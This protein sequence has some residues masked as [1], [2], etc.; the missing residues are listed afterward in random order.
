[1][2]D[3]D[4]A[5]FVVLQREGQCLAHFEVEVVGRLVEQQQ[6]GFGADQQG[7]R[8]PGFLAAGK[9]FDGA[10]RHVAAEVEAAE[11]VA[12]FLFRGG[13]LQPHQVLQR[14]FVGAQLFELVLGEVADVRAPSLPCARRLAA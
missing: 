9:G 7:Q 3:D 13:R 1:M 2:R 6:V 4:H 14:A 12:Q 5:A 8:Q 11:V 10:R